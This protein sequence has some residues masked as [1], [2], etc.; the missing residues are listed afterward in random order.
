MQATP[1][2]LLL[3]AFALVWARRTCRRDFAFGAVLSGREEEGG[4]ALGCLLSLLP[5][6]LK[7]LDDWQTLEG[8][9]GEVQ[10]GLLNLLDIN[11]QS[12]GCASMSEIR[13]WARLPRDQPVFDCAWIFENAPAVPEDLAEKAGYEL[14]CERE[15]TPAGDAADAPELRLS[16]RNGSCWASL[17]GCLRLPGSTEGAQASAEGCEG[18]LLLAEFDAVLSVLV[19][20]SQG[21]DSHAATVGDL[22]R[23]LPLLPEMQ[24]R[25][26]LRSSLTELPEESS[27]DLKD[28]QDFW[29]PRLPS[30]MEAA[31]ELPTV[32]AR[33]SVNSK[34]SWKSLTWSA[35]SP[36]RDA[37]AMVLASWAAVLS[38]ASGQDEVYVGMPLTSS[39]KSGELA[40]CAGNALPLLNSAHVYP[41]R[42]SLTGSKDLKSV[43]EDIELQISE[44]SLRAQY[45]RT[46][47][48]RF[49]NV[50]PWT[51][52]LVFGWGAAGA[53]ILSSAKGAL[54]ASRDLAGVEMLLLASPV[55]ESHRLNGALVWDAAAGL[56]QEQVERLLLRLTSTLARLAS[57]SEPHTQPWQ[58]MLSRPAERRS[59]LHERGVSQSAPLPEAG[60]LQL[61]LQ[62]ARRTP[63]SA[64]IASGE[65]AG[66]SPIALSYAD[67]VASAAATCDRLQLDVPS[68]SSEAAVGVLSERSPTAIVGLVAVL[69]A[70]AAYCPLLPSQPKERLVT[71]AA[72]AG[73][74]AVVVEEA[75]L[76]L[77]GLLDL[78]AVAIC[79]SRSCD[80]QRPGHIASTQRRSS[81]AMHVL[82]TSGS[83]GT[84][85]AVRASEQA[86]LSHL[87]QLIQSSKLQPTDVGLQHTSLAW[88]AAMP[89]VWAPLISGATL[90]VAPSSA[91]AKD[92]ET[93][94]AFAANGCSF[95]QYVPSVLE[96]MLHA[97]L[98]PVSTACRHLVLTGEP[99]STSLCKRLL[100][101]Q[102]SV[103]LRNHYGQT[104][105]ADT[106]TV[107][108][109]Q[110]PLPHAAAIPIGRPAIHRQVWLGSPSCLGDVGEGGGPGELLV[111]GPGLLIGQ[112]SNSGAL[113]ESALGAGVALCTG[114]LARWV[115]QEG[116]EDPDLV[117][118][119]RR[120]RQVK[121]RGHRVELAEVEAVLKEEAERVLGRPVEA[122]ALLANS[123]GRQQLVAYVRP[124]E[125]ASGSMGKD[126]LAACRSRLLAH[127][128][129]VAVVGVAEWPRAPGGKL[130]RKAL[131]PPQLA[132]FEAEASP[133]VTAPVGQCLAQPPRAS[134]TKLRAK[135]WQVLRALLAGALAGRC[136]IWR[137]LLLPFVWVAWAG[138]IAPRS[139][140]ARRRLANAADE[141]SPWLLSLVTSALLPNAAYV[142][143]AAFG[144]WRLG[145]RRSLAMPVLWWLG[146]SHVD[147][148]LLAELTWYGWYLT[149][150]RSLG[151][152]RVMLQR[153]SETLSSVTGTRQKRTIDWDWDRPQR[154]P[155]RRPR[156]DSVRVQEEPQGREND[157]ACSSAAKVVR[158]ELTREQQQL[159]RAVEEEA[160]SSLELAASLAS[161]FDS[162][163]LTALVAELRRSGAAPEITLRHALSC[164]TVADLIAHASAGQSTTGAAQ[165]SSATCRSPGRSTPRFF[166][167][168]EWRYMFRLSVCWALEAKT[169]VDLAA[170]KRALRRL[171]LRHA[172]LAAQ[173]ADPAQLWDFAMEAAGNLSLLRSLLLQQRQAATRRGRARS[174][175]LLPRTLNSLG[176]ALHR[177]WPRLVVHHEEQEAEV[178]L[179]VV[180]CSSCEQME[181]RSAWL[182]DGRNGRHF[183]EGPFHAVLLQLPAQST[184]PASAEEGPGSRAQEA[185]VPVAS[186]LHLAVS[187]GLCDGF[188]GT[189]L[190]QDFVR[191][192]ES[193]RGRARRSSDGS[194]DDAAAED[195]PST[196]GLELLESRLAGSL[197]GGDD[198]S[199]TADM[200]SWALPCAGMEGFDHFVW[201]HES[202]LLTLQKVVER[203]CW[204]CSLDV[205]LLAVLGTALARMAQH[206]PLSLRFTASARDGSGEGLMVADLADYRDLDMAFGESVAVEEAARALASCVRQRRWQLPSPLTDGEERVYLNFRPLL[207]EEIGNGPS[208][209]SSSAATGA[210]WKYRTLWPPVEGEWGWE[211]RNLYHSLWIMADQVAPME[212]VLCLKVRW[213]RP[214]DAQL[215]EVVESVVRDLALRPSAPL[216][217]ASQSEAPT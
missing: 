10:R 208:S 88:V 177:A 188:S 156:L 30:T 71:M 37:S 32:L 54:P 3:S 90:A 12:K 117:C 214:G 212:W 157:L 128:A 79:C 83:T 9:V 178:P 170:L 74:V 95:Q 130:D 72:I 24:Q 40:T 14:F 105:A 99:L 26:A 56:G 65:G 209:S 70:A 127:A 78:P 120:D 108:V 114:D 159:L 109:V 179:H 141:Q 41:I 132:G 200:S 45:S 144:V 60:V 134:D 183:S 161:V 152:A 46:S 125:L 2:A 106:T 184:L 206:G 107:F 21:A 69:L 142:S 191:L 19:T 15:L 73:L 185:E 94:A 87:L 154:R 28:L 97:G 155:R 61:L 58:T 153:G 162:L 203:S 126:L 82:F 181:Q 18:S 76:G 27:E 8:L 5:L 50:S 38:Q 102:P 171:R 29:C 175:G 190:L 195:M 140:A 216:R 215:G 211:R 52:R 145:L 64:A 186:R 33:G 4:K 189:P 96:A 36:A 49:A 172:A 7:L 51:P 187:H 42:C 17:R 167:V 166:K 6:R 115:W 75:L 147:S 201:L 113:Q 138:G 129:P 160:G 210:S 192:Y 146:L 119:G 173:L 98:K 204:Y 133:S 91:G 84:P 66:A 158:E 112:A 139:A 124:P 86:V 44:A 47:L 202:T 77:A 118:L 182:L 68:A 165:P 80:L 63:H 92:L 34:P 100:D 151:L 194:G 198:T 89:E 196:A 93:L 11:S 85:K 131:P 25:V 57:C 103:Q 81:A 135:G 149:P 213:D 59:L 150:G 116:A 205:A 16:R 123:H 23:A 53:E 217:S 31:L 104:E 20:P 193:E 148:Q 62:Q 67:L 136:R 180:A 137:M 13:S 35:R 39:K 55:E 101:S 121:I 48:E 111:A 110:R 168:R 22:L 174:A 197:G 207:Q 43:A 163:R 169:S 199:G 164:D 143:S 1:A 176:N 122:L